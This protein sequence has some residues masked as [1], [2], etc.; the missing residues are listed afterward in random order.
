[1]KFQFSKRRGNLL[2]LIARRCA[3]HFQLLL[4]SDAST[5]ILEGLALLL[6][7]GA[8]LN[9]RA[10]LI[11][12][13]Q[14]LTKTADWANFLHQFSFELSSGAVS[15]ITW[16]IKKRTQ[17]KITDQFV[18]EDF[19]HDEYGNSIRNAIHSS[20][21]PELKIF[22]TNNGEAITKPSLNAY[23]ACR[24]HIPLDISRGAWH[25]YEP[26]GGD[27]GATAGNRLMN[28]QRFVI[29]AAARRGD[30][31]FNRAKI[32]LATD[33]FDWFIGAPSQ[34]VKPIRVR[35]TDYFSSIITDGLAFKRIASYPEPNGPQL[36]DGLSSFVCHYKNGPAKAELLPLD[37]TRSANQ[38][39]V[40]TLAFSRDGKLILN[41]VSFRTRYGSGRIASSGSGSLNWHDLRSS[42]AHDLLTLVEFGACRELRE[43]CGLKANP[44]TRRPEIRCHVLVAGF[45]RLIHRG[46]KPEFLCVGFID[47]DYEEVA[48]RRVSLIESLFTT[49][50]DIMDTPTVRLDSASLSADIAHECKRFLSNEGSKQSLGQQLYL[51]LSLLSNLESEAALAKPI[52]AFLNSHFKA[53]S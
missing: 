1:M 46:G 27:G 29:L 19:Y 22:E 9:G 53:E 48:T 39:G 44:F 20:L 14:V 15:C 50:I 32:R 10:M 49:R 35:K 34:H 17:Y 33:M 28:L 43:E 7:L 52:T 37:R 8:V 41:R 11:A 26:S 51:G 31:I 45:Y 40:T 42:R 5:K 38:I 13:F 21:S 25:A 6:A 12:A 2:A 36:S 4:I 24:P 47:A 23:L 3:A 16:M 30:F 18:I